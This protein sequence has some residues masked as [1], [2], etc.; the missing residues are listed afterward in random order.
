V[1][2]I[3]AIRQRT[4]TV[5]RLSWPRSWFFPLFGQNLV[6]R[7][8]SPRHQIIEPIGPRSSLPVVVPLLE[9]PQDPSQRPARPPLRPLDQLQSLALLGCRVPA[10]RPQRRSPL[11]R[12]VLSTTSA[13]TRRLRSSSASSR[14]ISRVC[15]F[16]SSP[17]DPTALPASPPSPVAP[18]GRASSPPGDASARPHRR[19]RPTRLL[20]DPQLLSRRVHPP[21]PPAVPTRRRYPPR[22]CCGRLNEGKVS[23]QLEPQKP[24]CP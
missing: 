6:H 17:S 19:A 23:L 4:W 21:L 7:V 10:R 5:W 14:S 9:K 20:Q 11:L 24:D 8:P 1:H 3:R 16:R 12:Q 13:M 2:V 18:T 15:A 22:A